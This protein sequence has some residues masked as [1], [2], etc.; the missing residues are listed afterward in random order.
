MQPETS[1]HGQA[2]SP[3]R[4]VS[5]QLRDSPASEEA[6]GEAVGYWLAS[7]TGIWEAH[8]AWD[9][10]VGGWGGRSGW[11]GGRRS[12]RARRSLLSL[13]SCMHRRHTTAATH[14]HLPFTPTWYH[15]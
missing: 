3:P 13:F 2:A 15:S 1:S 11:S 5:A 12:R 7:F 6:F 8:A 10:K 4:N 9:P 14:R